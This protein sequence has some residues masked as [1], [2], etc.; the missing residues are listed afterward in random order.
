MGAESQSDTSP[1]VPEAD[2]RCTVGD[3]RHASKVGE[4]SGN[5]GFKS[6]FVSL[7]ANGEI[8]LVQLI[9]TN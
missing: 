6:S 9:I 5:G 8:S 3:T 4:R 7:G 1:F 2:R